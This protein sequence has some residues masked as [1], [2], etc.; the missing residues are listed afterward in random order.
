M[1][2][3]VL[4]E[5]FRSV[6]ASAAERCALAVAL[7]VLL[8]VATP[9]ASPGVRAAEGATD[10]AIRTRINT[11]VS[12]DVL[13]NDDKGLTVVEHTPVNHGELSSDGDGS[14]DYLPHANFTG[15]D[16][17]AY[18]V[19]NKEGA[20]F[21]ASVAIE[22]SGEVTGVEARNDKVQTDEDAAIWFSI[23]GNDGAGPDNLPLTITIDTPPTY[24]EVTPQDDGGFIY[25]PAANWFGSDEATYS[26]TD[27]VTTDTA[28]VTFEVASIADAPDAV[29][30]AILTDQGNP[31][32]IEVLANDSEAD[33]DGFS[34]V[35]HSQALFGSVRWSDGDRMMTYEPNPDHFG[36]D[37]FTYTIADEDGADT[38]TVTITVDGRPTGQDDVFAT[39]QGVAT[40]FN[41]LANDADPEAQPLAVTAV[42]RP[43]H[44]EV[45]I[46]PD[47]SVRY[48]AR[49]GF[50]GADTFSY[51]VEDPRGNPATANVTVNV[52]PASN[53]APV[54]R[55]DEYILEEDSPGNTLDV[56]TN[57]SDPDSN[58]LTIWIDRSPEHGDVT[59][60]T[61][62]IVTYTPDPDFSGT[63]TF[64]Y[65]ISDGNA[66][67]DSA[68]VTLIVRQMN[69]LPA[70][71]ADA[72]TVDEDTVT[73]LD[74]RANDTDPDGDELTIEAVDDPPSGTA[75]I[76]D[77]G[78]L[79]Y[80][81]DEN[82]SG[83]DSLT[84]TLSDGRG[85]TITAQVNITVSPVNDTPDA[86]NDRVATDIDVAID[87]NV[88]ANDRDADNPSLGVAIESGPADGSAVVAAGN[89]VRY[90]PNP[91]FEGVDRF[92]YLA[93]DASGATGTGTVIVIVGKPDLDPVAV[94][95]DARTTADNDVRIEVLENDSSPV[96][97]KLTVTEAT[98]PEH[99]S[100]RISKGKVISYSPDEGYVGK[101]SF[102]YTVTDAE[103]RTDKVRVYI[104]VRPA[105][106]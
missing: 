20:R 35:E 44:G 73:V 18:T 61:N 66:G 62:Q 85:G 28:T 65:S 95:D 14:F 64:V 4:H 71:A 41:V 58:P 46:E 12:F 50:T 78:E 9:V 74:V 67:T 90:V 57:D 102:V 31:V 84:Y 105:D 88:L 13:A 22:V 34:Y 39:S 101:D 79:V 99:G 1:T 32:E 3:A 6:M 103:G 59:V 11:A 86:R 92:T 19:E 2:G 42:T 68:T 30:D 27:G 54:A 53:L 82:Y 75:T 36:S 106:E 15:A 52:A 80:Q 49:A 43:E 7:L 29:D 87:F 96:D 104:N 70:A 98:D 83:P 72:F 37:S 5:G 76:D 91:E 81:P 51:T 24:G 33:G 55:D 69:D 100:I 23:R 48:V 26:L 94:K 38:A 93:V 47:F 10:D 45:T 40:T 56:L 77:R 21:S 8:V 25:T 63:D 97:S 17:F 16:G 60:G 89:T